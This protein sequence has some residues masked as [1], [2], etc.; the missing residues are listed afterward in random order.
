[1][2]Y[3]LGGTLTADRE[4]S[5][6]GAAHFTER[7]RFYAAWW[8]LESA[9]RHTDGQVCAAQPVAEETSITGKHHFGSDNRPLARVP[10]SIAWPWLGAGGIDCE[11]GK[12]S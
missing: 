4:R 5:I 11:G 7:S 2:E 9:Y 8:L 3:W 1:V 10:W 12:C 6:E